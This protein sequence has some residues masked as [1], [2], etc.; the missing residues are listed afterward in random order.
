MAI[1]RGRPLSINAVEVCTNSR[2]KLKALNIHNSLIV[3]SDICPGRASYGA[4]VNCNCRISHA[5]IDASRIA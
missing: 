5:C 1:G 2:Y 4:T 3:T